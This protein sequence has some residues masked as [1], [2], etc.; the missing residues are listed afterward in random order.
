M[1]GREELRATVPRLG[2]DAPLPGGGTLRDIAGEVLAIARA[3]LNARG[4]LNA[5]G[6]NEGG[7]LAP[8]DEIV[9]RGKVPAEMLLERYHGEWQGDV[10]RVYEEKSF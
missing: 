7:F 8:L 1:A 5:A 2:L 6:D 9:T 3:G 10:A 4:K